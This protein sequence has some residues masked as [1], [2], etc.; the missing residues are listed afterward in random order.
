MGRSWPVSR[1]GILGPAVRAET[2]RFVLSDPAAGEARYLTGFAPPLTHGD[3]AVLKAQEWVH[4]RDGRG[5]SLCGHG[6]GR[7]TGTAHAAAAVRE[8]NGHESDRVLSGRSHCA[9]ARAPHS[10]NGLA[11]A[12]LVAAT[13]TLL[14]ELASSAAH[15]ACTPFAMGNAAILKPDVQTPIIGGVTFARLLE[16]AV[17][18]LLGNLRG[19]Q[20]CN[21]LSAG[22]NWIRTSSSGRNRMAFQGGRFAL[23]KPVK[24]ATLLSRSC[25]ESGECRLRGEGRDER[26]ASA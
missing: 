11:N 8:C 25:R 17:P 9:S 12:T 7:G 20:V 4:M 16:E 26:R 22:G 19:N 6:D 21:G 18:P 3:R 23:P 5:V 2:A 15:A 24:R 13:K 1:D 10:A 14:R